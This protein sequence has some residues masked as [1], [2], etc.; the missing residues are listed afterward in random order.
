MSRFRVSFNRCVVAVLALVVVG[1]AF[2]QETQAFPTREIRLIVPWPPGGAIDI[3]ARTLQSVLQ[4]EGVRIVV[5]NRPGG[6]SAIGLT[7]LVAAPADGY[8]LAV[9][10]SA[11]LGLAA[12]GQAPITP[13]QFTNIIQTSEDPLLLL[14]N[15]DAPWKTIDEFMYHVIDNPGQVTVGT[16]G[17]NNPIHAMAV[18]TGRSVNSPI[19]HVP[20]DGGAPVAA[21]L[22]GGHIDAGVFLPSLAMTHVSS[23]EL[24]A[25]A[26]YR[27]ERMAAFPD[28]PTF[29]ERGY[30]VLEMGPIAQVSW[31]V[32]PAGLDPAT[33]DQ[34]AALFMKAVS[35]E[36]FQK[37][38]EQNGVIAEG[39]TGDALDDYISALHEAMS[40]AFPELFA[41]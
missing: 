36:P 40:R 26:V 27:A 14:V 41:P 5:D 38:A 30:D 22:M 37:W 33:R 10:T 25:L 20:F 13:D 2:P 21:A 7:Q 32:A 34:L 6:G 39:V 8:T 12:L 18:L 11:I 3:M 9:A 19:R 1:F 31:I 4:E 23:G 29:I 35:S 28:V 24:R 16:P 15:Q 17:V